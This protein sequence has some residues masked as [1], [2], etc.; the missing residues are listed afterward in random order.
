VFFRSLATRGARE[1]P[2]NIPDIITACKA[3]R[4]DLVILETPGIGQGDAAV[5]ELADVSLYMMTP[6]YGAASQLEKID[7]LGFADVVA[8]NKFERRRAADALRDVTR[9]EPGLGQDLADCALAGSMAQ[10]GRLALDSAVSPSRVLPG[11]VQ[12]QV[13]DLLCDGRASSPARVGPFPFEPNDG[14]RRARCRASR[15]DEPAGAQAAVVSVQRAHR[16]RPDPA[17]GR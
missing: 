13:A 1:L 6:E 15:S 14:A 2:D 10:A 3:A 9:A 17:S 7:M 11:Q 12:D 16:G 4:Y 8:V 5:V